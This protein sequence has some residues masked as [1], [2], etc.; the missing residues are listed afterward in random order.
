MVEDPQFNIRSEAE[1]KMYLEQLRNRTLEARIDS[2]DDRNFV[3]HVFTFQDPANHPARMVAHLR[4]SLLAREVR[5]GIFEASDRNAFIVDIGTM[6]DSQYEHY[7][8]QQAER[9]KKLALVETSLEDEDLRKLKSQAGSAIQSFPFTFNLLRDLQ[10]EDAVKSADEML[11]ELTDVAAQAGFE[12]IGP[13][14]NKT[15]EINPLK[16]PHFITDV[17]LAKLNEV[18]RKS[19]SRSEEPPM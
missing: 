10:P 15:V 7:Q 19:I 18:I 12:E 8:F 11:R 6:T 13:I 2:Q 4:A 3:F 1:L 9:E 17:I 14:V 16:P 5:G